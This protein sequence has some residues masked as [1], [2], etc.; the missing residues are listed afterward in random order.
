MPAAHEDH[1]LRGGEHVFAADWAVAVGGALDVFVGLGHRYGHAEA[2]F[3]D[4][5]IA[6]SIYSEFLKMKERGVR[7]KPVPCN[8]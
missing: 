4:P 8:G 1:G 5:T 6:I 7:G 2:A 3:L